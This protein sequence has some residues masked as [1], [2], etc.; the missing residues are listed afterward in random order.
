[1]TTISP[2]E[3][4]NEVIDTTATKTGLKRWHVIAAIV[5]NKHYQW[6][7]SP[8]LRTAF[9]SESFMRSFFVLTF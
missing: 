5:G 1:V 6:S 2:L 7:I 8:A 9:L 3:K 4:I